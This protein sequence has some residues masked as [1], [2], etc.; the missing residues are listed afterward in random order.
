M[1]TTKINSD[2]VDTTSVATLV[3]PQLLTNK[4]LQSPLETVTI[5]AAAPAATT[6]FDVVTQSIQ[7]YTTN[8]ANNFTWNVRGNS[9][10]TL[11]SLMAVGQSITIAL[12]VTNG[13]T[14]Y[15]PTVYQVDGSA[16]T[17][18]YQGGLS[19]A[20]GNASSIDIYS[21]TLVKTASATFTGFVSQTKFA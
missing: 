7:Y 8:A 13:S 16:I 12:F 3:A 9:G 19:I 15:Y 4:T 10:T 20:G 14:A 5:T 11:N 1:T 21:L 17:P 6:N 18:K 2:N